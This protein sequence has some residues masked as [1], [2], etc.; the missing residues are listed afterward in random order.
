MSSTGT[1]LP[2]PFVRG[3]SDTAHVFF[4][5]ATNA[6]HFERS[7]AELH[8]R[9]PDGA[10][11]R[12]CGP[13]RHPL[14]PGVPSRADGSLLMKRF[15]IPPPQ[16]LLYLMTGGLRRRVP[17]IATSRFLTTPA[18]RAPSKRPTWTQSPKARC[19]PRARTT[20]SIAALR[21]RS[22]TR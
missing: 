4:L 16:P 21:E 17:D 3:T 8:A 10:R 22:H 2:S 11:L 6:G 19:C 9:G 20:S 15:S 7:D 1:P 18:Q 5:Q 13:R 12:R 14:G